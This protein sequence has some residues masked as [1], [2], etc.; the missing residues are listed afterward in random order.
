LANAAGVSEALL[1]KHFPS[2]ESLYAAMLDHCAKGPGLVEYNRILALV[3]STSTLVIMVHFLIS[4][5]VLGSVEHANREALNRLAV[6]SLLEDG[7]FVRVAHRK[8][9]DA[10]I[11][12]F[13]KCLKAAAK[14]GELRENPVHRHLRGWFAHHIAF[15]LMLH[16]HPK[17]PAV[18][19]RISK[20][21]L[22]RQAVWFVLLG[23]G[24]KEEAIQLHYNPEAFALL[25]G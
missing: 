17:L 19:Y 1:Y 7:A 22:V 18:N 21:A 20:E 4:H 2:K 23:A 25:T 5:F 12:Q 3:P 15:A 13:E 14:A 6:R 24:V 8:F 10:F 11:E 16:F 9:T